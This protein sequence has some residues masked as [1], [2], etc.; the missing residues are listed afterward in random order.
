MNKAM[1]VRHPVEHIVG[2]TLQGFNNFSG[3]QNPNSS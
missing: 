1:E 3:V 2:E